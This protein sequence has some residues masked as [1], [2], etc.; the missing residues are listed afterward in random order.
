MFVLFYRVCM[1]VRLF[2]LETINCVY[3]Y[4]EVECMY[5]CHT[6]ML[7]KKPYFFVHVVVES[8]YT[9]K[10]GNFEIYLI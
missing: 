2:I 3:V 8:M 1:H 9:C 7:A 4:V 6:G 5:T 10:T